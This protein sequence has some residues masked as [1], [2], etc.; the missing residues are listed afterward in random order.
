MLEKLFDH[1]VPFCLISSLHCV[2]QSLTSAPLSSN[3]G[4]MPDMRL[5]DPSNALA[6][7]M[8]GLN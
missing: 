6:T 5:S 4:R 7:V 2:S 8:F 3:S 1:G